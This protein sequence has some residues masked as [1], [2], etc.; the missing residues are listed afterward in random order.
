MAE[1]KKCLQKG[2]VGNNNHVYSKYYDAEL[3]MFL[4][5]WSLILINFTYEMSGPTLFQNVWIY[6]LFYKCYELHFWVQQL[7]TVATFSHCI[8]VEN[9]NHVYSKYYNADL[10]MFLFKWSLIL[11]NFTYKMSGPTLFQ[12]VWIYVLF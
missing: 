3:V 11:I 2:I 10:V 8:N 7:E 6:V 4:F 1:K 12:N 5:Q 9:H